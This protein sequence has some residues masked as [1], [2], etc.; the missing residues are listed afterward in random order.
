MCSIIWKWR[1][2][3]LFFL[4]FFFSKVKRTPALER[5]HFQSFNWFEDLCLCEPLLLH[6]RVFFVKRLF[7]FSTLC[8][9]FIFPGNCLFLKRRIRTGKNDSSKSVYP[10]CSNLFCLCILKIINNFFDFVPHPPI[11]LLC[12]SQ[13]FSPAWDFPLLDP[14]VPHNFAMAHENIIAQMSWLIKQRTK[15]SMWLHYWEF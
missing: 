3:F 12:T 10:L 4:S 1:V 6:I 9:L 5:R 7:L 2:F 13:K 14:H 8:S 15:G 11:L